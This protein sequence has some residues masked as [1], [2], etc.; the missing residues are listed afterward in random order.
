MD[1]TTSTSRQYFQ[2]LLIIGLILIII[3]SITYTVISGNNYSN[4][5]YLLKYTGSILFG[6]LVYFI[7]VIT[8]ACLWKANCKLL[9][10]LHL[11][12]IFG[13]LVLLIGNVVYTI[14]NIAG[15]NTNNKK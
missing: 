9:A 5:S 15:A 13:L 12:Y 2:W 14:T 6:F 7:M 11:L 1:S 8:A 10:G 4:S 3:N